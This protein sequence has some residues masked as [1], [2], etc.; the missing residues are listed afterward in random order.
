MDIDCSKT[1]DDKLKFQAPWDFD[2]PFGIVQSYEAYYYANNLY[3][4]NSCN[5][6]LVLLYK[7]NKVKEK[8]NEKW[9][10]MNENKVLDSFW[11]TTTT[12]K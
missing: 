5:P 7:S 1:G 6:W 4:A 2:I 10:G 3:A 8:I 9:L 11:L 12:N